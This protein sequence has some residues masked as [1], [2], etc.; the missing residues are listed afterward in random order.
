MEEGRMIAAV[1]GILYSFFFFVFTFYMYIYI[2][3]KNS[4]Y[5]TEILQSIIAW[6][7]FGS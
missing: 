3:S 1:I 2:H 4:M 5:L 6:S 7:K